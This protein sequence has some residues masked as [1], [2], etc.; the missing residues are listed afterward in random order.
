M[1]VLTFVI[2]CAHTVFSPAHIIVRTLWFLVHTRVYDLCVRIR[3]AIFCVPVCAKDADCV[4][5]TLKGGGAHHHI[6]HHVW[7]PIIYK[8]GGTLHT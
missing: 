8:Y 1:R 7:F 4:Q 3:V 6:S 2:F 5:N